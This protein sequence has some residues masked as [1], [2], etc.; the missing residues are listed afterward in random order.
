[1]SYQQAIY[2][3]GSNDPAAFSCVSA[4]DGPGVTR[5]TLT[6]ELDLATAPELRAAIHDAAE[7]AELVIVDLSALAF[8]DSAGLCT[9]VTA[10][11]KLRDAGRRL[12]LTPG[13]RQVQR[14][15][16]LTGLADTLP[17]TN[18]NALSRNGNSR[19]LHSIPPATA[20]IG[21]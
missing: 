20:A 17:F 19:L 12:A 6:G 13:Q 21:H 8:M 14:V 3:P 5:L 10:H 16:E 11:R 18:D 15:F 4:P 9:I 2:E 1:M 7:D